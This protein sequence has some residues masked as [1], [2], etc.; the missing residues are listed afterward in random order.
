MK[1]GYVII[2]HG[3]GLY[4]V[5]YRD[6]TGTLEADNGNRFPDRSSAEAQRRIWE[7][8]DQI[9]RAS[10]RVYRSGYDYACGYHD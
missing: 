7:N 1:S 9:T 4:E 3:K 6:K 5:T 10:E 2:K 8:D